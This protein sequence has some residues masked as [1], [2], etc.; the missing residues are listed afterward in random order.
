[1]TRTNA[2][3]RRL[4]GLA[5]RDCPTCR[6]WGPCVYEIGDRWPER[7][8]CCPACGRHVAIQLLR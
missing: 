8:E 5:P 6:F 2:Q 1:M 4:E 7:G 3:L